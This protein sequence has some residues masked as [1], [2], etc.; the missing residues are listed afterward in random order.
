MDL[1]GTR[2]SG[3]DATTQAA[4]A[5]ADTQP[6]DGSDVTVPGRGEPD[7]GLETRRL[8]AALEAKLFGAE[9]DPVSVGRFEIIGKL[10]EGAMGAVYRARDPGLDREVAVKLI[11]GKAFASDSAGE[12][13]HERLRREARALAS[14]AHPNVVAVLD[15]GREAGQPFVAMELVDAGTLLDW[16]ESN[17]LGAPGRTK[18]LVS[19]L[20]QACRGLAAAHR[21]GVVHRDVK[22][23]NMLIGADGRLRLADFGLARAAA[24]E[25]DPDSELQSADPI[26]TSLS[27]PGAVAGTPAYM[28]PEQFEGRTDERSDQF[29]LCA[30]FWEAAYGQRPFRGRNIAALMAA[31]RDLPPNVPARAPRLPRAVRRVLL[32]GLA[33]DPAKRFASIDALLSELRRRRGLGVA[34]LLSGGVAAAAL[35]VGAQTGGGEQP[36]CDAPP[37]QVR[38]AWGTRDRLTAR[39]RFVAASAELGPAVFERVDSALNTYADAW[40]KGWTA[41]CVATRAGA[42]SD[43]DFD[44]RMQCLSRT[45]RVH[46][47]VLDVLLA[48]E[49]GATDPAKLADAV[50]SLPGVEHCA[51]LHR[52]RGETPLPEDPAVRAEIGRLDAELET[53]RTLQFARAFAEGIAKM[54]ALRGPVEATGYAPLRVRWA[55]L[56]ADHYLVDHDRRALQ[57]GEMALALAEEAGLDG[58][59]SEAALRVW[60]MSERFG[61]PQSETR[62]YLRKAKALAERISDED[63]REFYRALVN[64]SEAIQLRLDGKPEEALVKMREH[65]AYFETHDGPE[66]LDVAGAL[67]GAGELLIDLGRFEEAE[68]E[69]LRAR[70]IRQLHPGRRWDKQVEIATLL[71]RAASQQRHGEDAARYGRT[72]LDLTRKHLGDEHP[73]YLSVLGNLGVAQTYS[74]ELDAALETSRRVLKLMKK[75]LEPGAA[76]QVIA[77]MNLADQLPEG[78]E[79][80]RL[81]QD[82]YDVALEHHG[83]ESYPYAL[84]L[85]AQGRHAQRTEDG[86]R[87][88]RQIRESLAIFEARGRVAKI[89]RDRVAL[90]LS[91]SQLAQYEEAEKLA[92]RVVT[93]MS[94]RLGSDSKNLADPY[95][96]H[97]TALHGLG[98]D[99]AARDALVLAAE[100]V[101]KSDT[102]LGERIETLKAAL[103]GDEP[104]TRK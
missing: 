57:F 16:C 100:R 33:K 17:P 80:V 102:D 56:S 44:L 65:Q 87:A 11:A 10:G 29:S 60:E 28:A 53:Q 64:E 5:L 27:T 54:E 31:I 89:A 2:G 18:A 47:A 48:G 101:E 51:D 70:D 77:R 75:V 24:V 7:A 37:A 21:A 41:A 68:R 15:V 84:A 63:D 39:A 9:G 93:E 59:A 88:V 67:E 83:V 26:V 72:A 1:D 4:P 49:P 30:S 61:S 69:L 66:A 20:E 97:A 74:G 43:A 94:E 85:S 86:E 99:D 13:A 22:P 25:T 95:Y 58:R 96:C 36:R 50:E 3:S 23:Q 90:S 45:Q 104:A 46:A 78:E 6:V 62:L 35:F 19:L 73:L 32:R 81:Y 98:R 92:L 38:D 52:L 82:A 34:V 103:D 14:L 12:V 71:M 42:Q 55:L 40:E 76:S 8:I 91:L 79:K